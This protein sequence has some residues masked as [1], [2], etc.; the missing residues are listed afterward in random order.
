MAK[1]P[2]GLPLAAAAA[3]TVVTLFVP[4]KRLH[5]ACGAAWAALSLVHAWQYR[6]RLAQDLVATPLGACL[7]KDVMKTVEAGLQKL[8]LPPTKLGALIGSMR[9]AAYAPGRMRLYSRSLMGNE[10]L[11]EQ[12]L[13]YFADCPEVDKV[14]CSTLT[15][16]VLITYEP[17][18]FAENEELSQIET[19]VKHHVQMAQG[20]S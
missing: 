8:P 16:S 15:G 9:P 3:G 5:I 12:I 4:A 11:R 6:R 13:A 18:F 10:K 7:K 17:E 14:E 1:I 2:L 19:Y 20:R